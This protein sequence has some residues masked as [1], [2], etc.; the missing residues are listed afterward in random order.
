M[1]AARRGLTG[2]PNATM[3]RQLFN[4]AA[5]HEPARRPIWCGS[6]LWQA[7]TKLKV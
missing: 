1:L 5:L 4:K 6:V 3:E 7:K 2:S